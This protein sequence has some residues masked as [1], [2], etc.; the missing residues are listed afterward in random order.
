MN[1]KDTIVIIL[2]TLIVLGF[3]LL[4]YK[5]QKQ[6]GD[7]TPDKQ[8]LQKINLTQRYTFLLILFSLLIVFCIMLSYNIENFTDSVSLM[9]IIICVGLL[10]LM[11][12]G[13]LGILQYQ[14]RQIDKLDN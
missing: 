5:T 14:A 7:Y 2:C 13:I 3:S 6:M 10:I 4:L 1:Y 8:T 9:S 12:I 11:C